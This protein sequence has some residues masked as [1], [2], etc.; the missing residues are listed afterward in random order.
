MLRSAKADPKV[1]RL[2]NLSPLRRCSDPEL[3]MLA[4]LLDEGR[5][6]EGTVLIKEGSVGAEFF[7]I[8][9]GLASVTIAGKHIATLGPGEV[10]GEM[11]VVSQGP[12]SATVTAKTDMQLFVAP[13]QAFSKM[14]EDAPPFGLQVLAAVIDRLRVA[15]TA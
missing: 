15:E 14:F 12:R 13:A 3:A 10:I 7:I 6:S 4:R 8:E 2:R 1:A 11:S 5:V 9:Q